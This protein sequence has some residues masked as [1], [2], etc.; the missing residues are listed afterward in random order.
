MVMN[1]LKLIAFCA[2]LS[3]FAACGEK[4]CTYKPEAVFAKDL[5]H[6]VDYNFERDGN[7]SM[8]SML[9]DTQVMLELYQNICEDTYQE[10][11]FTVK[12]DFANFPDSLWLKEASRQ[13][14]FLSTL[15]EKQRPLKDWG[16][17][18]ELR[19][20]DMKLGENREVEQ[21]IYVKVDKVVGPDQGVLLVTFSNKEK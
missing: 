21:G 3:L 20:S 17:I 15:S 9:F 10:Y 5:P 8:E 16:D 4:K 2:V 18:I 1:A 19:R 12:G 7:Q 14:V 11:K 13:L 6:V